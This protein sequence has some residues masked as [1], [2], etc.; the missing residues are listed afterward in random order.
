[1]LAQKGMAWVSDSDA[2]PMNTPQVCIPDIT[3]AGTPTKAGACARKPSN[4]PPPPEN[5][6]LRFPK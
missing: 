1:L 5:L 4:Q 2:F 6:A 3:M